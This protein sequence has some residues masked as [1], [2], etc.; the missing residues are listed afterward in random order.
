MIDMELKEGETIF[1]KIS[2]D[3]DTIR[4]SSNPIKPLK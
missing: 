4:Q 3:Y 1:D 2:I